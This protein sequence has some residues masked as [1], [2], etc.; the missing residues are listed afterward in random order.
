ME[1]QPAT[2][3]DFFEALI[4]EQA[5]GQR[6]D[7]YLAQAMAGFS[8]SAV[9]KMLEAQLVTVNDKP[10]KA[11]Q[12][13]KTGDTI[14]AFVPPPVALEAQ[15]E[16]MPL[17]IVYE[18]PHL[19]VVDK[20]KGLVVH[21]GAGNT[22]GTL[23]S[24]LLHHCRGQLSGINGVLRPGIVHRIDKDTSGLLVVAKTDAA[25]RHLSEQL[26]A[27]SVDRA[28]NAIVHG[29][30]KT[31]AGTVNAPV[32]RHPVQRTKMA[33][34]H[35]HGKHAVTHYRVLE[36]FH[37]HTFIEARLETG[38]THQI[39]VHMASLGHPLLGD[40]VYGPKTS[41]PACTGQA[42][43][44]RLLGFTHP[45]TG[46]RLSFESPLPG[47]FEALLQQLRNMQ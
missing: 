7:A 32:G 40:D 21:P 12:K 14:A 41:K 36:A 24:G 10:A 47:Y 18:D 15:P 11:G 19:L 30:L 4:S 2:Y 31:P 44:A 3:E 27:H 46:E 9:Q 22:T 25:H 8:R 39:R 6:L 26:A 23:V 13:L 1:Q 29:V 28:Y 34:N 43:H 20:P 33:I 17:A 42:L 16:A 35:H 37:K 45:A 5:E 38:R